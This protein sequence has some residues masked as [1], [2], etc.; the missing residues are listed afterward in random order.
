MM[1]FILYTGL[2]SVSKDA[3]NVGFALINLRTKE[4]KYYHIS[5]DSKNIRQLSSARRKGNKT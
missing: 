3:S 1:M 4:G 2:T 5:G